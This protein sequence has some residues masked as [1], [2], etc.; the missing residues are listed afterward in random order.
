MNA[1]ASLMPSSVAAIGNFSS[2][3]ASGGRSVYL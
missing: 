3:H 1:P 2:F